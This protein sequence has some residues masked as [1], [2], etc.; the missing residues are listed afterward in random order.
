MLICGYFFPRRVAVAHLAWILALYAGTLAM[1][2]STAGYS[3]LTRWLFTAVSLTVVMLLTSEI[4]RRRERADTRA[5][6]F[7]ELSQDM[8]STMDVEG[9]CVE[10]N[11]AWKPCLGYGA[12]DM[13]GRPLLSSPTRTTSTA[14][15]QQ[16]QDVFH[17]E[18]VG[19]PRDAGAGQGRQLALAA[20]DCDLRRPTSSLVYARST[21]VT[22]L[23]EVEAEREELLRRGRADG[24]Q[25]RAHRPAQPPRPRGA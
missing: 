11:A 16:A 19:R 24:E 4:V 13:E 17:G 21:D 18:E 25:R 1:V 22:E 10:V 5:R 14:P 15:S 6:R 3:P 2:E 8:L 7:F 23:K 9:R 20:L 12:A